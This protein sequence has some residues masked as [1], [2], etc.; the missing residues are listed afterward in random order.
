MKQNQ[1]EALN[2]VVWSKCPKIKFTS[3]Q[4][5]NLAVCDSIC[6]F[7]TAAAN[8]AIIIDINASSRTAGFRKEDVERMK[9]AERKISI[10]SRSKRRADNKNKSDIYM[11][12]TKLAYFPGAFG[13]SEPD[14]Y[15]DVNN[16]GT[17]P[18]KKQERRNK[19]DEVIKSLPEKQPARTC[20]RTET[21]DRIEQHKNNYCG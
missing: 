14:I 11:H 3:K 7:N 2:G 19:H 4:K 5:A 18:P 16:A 1:N 8:K 21:D 10:S 9:N 17:I 12:S 13:L 20:T 15:I 6:Q